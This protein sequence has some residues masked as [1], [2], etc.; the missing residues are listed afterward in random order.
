[1]MTRALWTCAALPA[2]ALLG[3]N[4]TSPPKPDAVNGKV[5]PQMRSG[6]TELRTYQIEDWVAPDDRTLVVNS[7]DR[8]L[9]E[10]RFKT[11]CTG[12]RLV[13][14]LAF[15]VSEP[16]QIASYVGIVLPDGTRCVFASF[17]R[18]LA[19]P[20]RSKDAAQDE[21]TL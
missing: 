20:A 21:G 8:S 15:I 2:L 18:L 19:P 1:M 12:L 10:G 16:P 11:R 4:T 14:T 17:T 3:C 7:V 9:F 13:N 5:T 6:S